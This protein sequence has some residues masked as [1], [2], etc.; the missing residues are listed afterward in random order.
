MIEVGKWVPICCFKHNGSFHR[1]WDKSMVLDDNDEFLV[2]ANET[3]NVIENDGRC[4]QAKDPA[5]TFFFKHEWYN[6]IC[7]LRHNG[8]HYYCNI[9]SPYMVERDTILY[10]DY[11]LDI[12]MNNDSMIKI[13]DELEYIKHANDMNYGPDLDLILKKSLYNVGVMCM[14][15]KFP[16]DD[17]LVNKYYQKFLEIKNV[18]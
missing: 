9:A 7:M 12:G 2:V 15:H 11:D 13:L 10:V 3:A 6:V 1:L 14:D 18:K 8:I 17:N 4:W 5:V 16:F